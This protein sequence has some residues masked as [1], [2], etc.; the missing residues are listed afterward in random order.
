MPNESVESEQTEMS[1]SLQLPVQEP[2]IFRY[3]P[4]AEMLHFLSNHR[5][6]EYTI[7]RLAGQTHVSENTVRKALSVL[8]AN[9]LISS[10]T[11]GA[12]RLVSINTERL[13]VPADPVT[14]IPQPEYHEP[15]QAAVTKLKENLEDIVGILLYGS[16]AQGTADRQSDI[17]L[18]VLVRENR[19]QAQRTANTIKDN[20]ES[21]RFNNPPGPPEDGGERF[22]FDIDVETVPAIPQYSGD[23]LHILNTSIPLYTTGD[24][25][26]VSA[27]IDRIT[28][29]PT[30]DE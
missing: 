13:D 21:K 1:I 27:I 9:D 25:E 3:Q 20:L 26:K 10:R 24:F 2:K 12:K 17:D 7:K 15:V 16:V 19:A 29:P 4:T 14:Q 30:D 22:G 18:W 5:Y 11:D 8:E 23:I 28:S 6:E